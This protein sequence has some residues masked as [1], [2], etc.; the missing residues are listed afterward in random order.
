MEIKEVE[1]EKPDD[2]NFILGQTHFIKSVEDLYEAMANVPGAKFGIAFCEASGPCLVRADGNDDGLKGLAVKN[3]MA[4]GAGHSFLIFMK[5]CF[6][7]NVLNSIKNVPE[8][9]RIY[10]ATANPT[11]VLVAESTMGNERGRGIVGVIDGYMPKGIEGE[12]DVKKRKEFLR[13]IGYK[14]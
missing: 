13:T 9:C 3:A 1:I 6:P 4:I 2:M 11:K 5:N 14:R 12:D 10:C 7:I 8:V